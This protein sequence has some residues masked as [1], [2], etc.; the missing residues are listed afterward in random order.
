MFQHVIQTL[1]IPSYHRSSLCSH[2][3]MRYVVAM[4]TQNKAELHHRNDMQIPLT[5]NSPISKNMQ[6]KWVSVRSEM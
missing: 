3:L 5:V 6:I 4:T 1:A 2:P